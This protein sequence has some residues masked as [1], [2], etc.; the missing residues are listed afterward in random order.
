MFA[1]GGVNKF[2]LPYW[3]QMRLMHEL[4]HLVTT[5][6]YPFFLQRYNQTA[7]TVTLVTGTEY[8]TQINTV[9]AKQRLDTLATGLRNRSDS[10]PK[11]DNYD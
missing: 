10:H 2:P 4:A 6:A 5:N 9:L 1:V 7:A 8:S 3:L 11:H